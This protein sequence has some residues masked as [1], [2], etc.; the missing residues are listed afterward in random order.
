MFIYNR[1]EMGNC[2]ASVFICSDQEKRIQKI[3]YGLKVPNSIF[4]LATLTLNPL[5]GTLQ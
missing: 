2:F 4:I 5:K 3:F 1:G